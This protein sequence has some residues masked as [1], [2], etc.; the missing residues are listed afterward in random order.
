[1][2]EIKQQTILEDWKETMELGKFVLDQEGLF[3]LEDWGGRESIYGVLPENLLRVF[4][5][6]QPDLVDTIIKEKNRPTATAFVN[7]LLDFIN[8]INERRAAGSLLAYNYF[9][10]SVEVLLA[11]GITPICV[12]LL[13]GLCGA[14]YVNGCESGIDRIEAEGYPDHLCSTQKGTAGFLLD[15]YVEKPDMFVKPTAP[16]DPSNKMYE[17]MGRAMGVPLLVVES[18]YY[19]NERGIKFLADEYRRFIEKLEKITG[20]SLDEDKLREYCTIGNETVE[21]YLKLQDLKRLKPCPDPGWHRPADTAFLTGLG[22][23]MCRDYFKDV[24]AAVK[25]NADA[26]KGVIP[27]GMK[28]KRFAWGYTWEVYDLPFF[29]WLE[30]KHGVVYI[31][32]T[33]TYMAP[34]IGTV[35]TTN[36]DTMI[37]GL[38]WRMMNLPMGRQTMGFSDTWINDFV[39]V[40]RRYSCDALVMGGH[41]ACKHFWALNK[42]MS[43]EIKDKTGVPTLRFEMDMFDKRFT[44]PAELKRI[45]GEFVE[46]T[47]PE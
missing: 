43:D 10:I 2:S 1:M 27:E 14:F 36:F 13:C 22:T 12:E 6:I 28:E 34:D 15:G 25:A 8:F 35:D 40:V 7:H 18:P 45:V 21:Y 38:A 19:R 23:P 20:C 9:A 39:D 46:T 29:D 26:G 30:E 32:D 41:M 5:M 17:Y 37:E 3:D 31:A 24:Y 33:L 42:L 11:M 44:P 4:D 47:F 16:C